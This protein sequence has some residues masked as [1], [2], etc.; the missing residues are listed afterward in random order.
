[1]RRRR[2]RAA[3]ECTEPSR[4]GPLPHESARAGPMLDNFKLH[5]R[6]PLD[7]LPFLKEGDSYGS[8]CRGSCFNADCPPGELP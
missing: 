6:D 1:L 3:T 7:F 4:H 8:R 5:E 2:T